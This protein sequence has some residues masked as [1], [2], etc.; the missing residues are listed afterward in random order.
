[1]DFGKLHDLTGLQFTL[2]SD[3]A[4]TATVLGGAPA[5]GGLQLFAGGTGWSMPGWNGKWYPPKAKQKDFLFHYSR[6]FNTIELNT[7]HY[8]IPDR[9]TINQWRENAS[10]GFRF[11]PK[12]PQ[13][14]SHR[15]RLHQ[16]E[17]DVLE[18]C[19]SVSGLEEKLG[20]SFLQ[21]PPDFG[22]EALPRFRQFI[23]AWPEEV[24]LMIEFRHP[25]WFGISAKAVD[26]WELMEKLGIGAVI[27]DV[28]GRRDVLHMH[29]TTR[30]LMLR[31]VGNT[32]HPTDFTRLADWAGRIRQWRD[33]GLERAILF[34]HQPD[35]ALMPEFAEKVIPLLNQQLGTN[36]APPKRV[37]VAQQGT[38]FG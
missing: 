25:E 19:A 17:R 1:M 22:P 26:G 35:N 33:Q 8:R 36:I 13:V 10:E 21:L 2:P 32:L 11:C 31:F 34:L 38:L 16:C 6:Q 27:T 29:L 30:T 18:F 24:P 3:H 23:S 28:A 5:A 37:E 20:P 4:R 9:D 12:V 7:T 14:I 15:K